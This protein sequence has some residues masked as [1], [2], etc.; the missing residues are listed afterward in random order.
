MNVIFSFI[1]HNIY[2][3][4]TYKYFIVLHLIWMLNSIILFHLNLHYYYTTDKQF[5]C[6]Y[7][8]Y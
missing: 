1:N 5:K 2:N 7:K 8:H 6:I 4:Y 3:K